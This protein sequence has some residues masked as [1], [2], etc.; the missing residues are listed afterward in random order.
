MGGKASQNVSLV[1]ISGLS[2]RGAHWGILWLWHDRGETMFPTDFS[3]DLNSICPL[4]SLTL[5]LFSF[6]FST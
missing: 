2:Q 4:A 3:P 1:R 5:G 6:P